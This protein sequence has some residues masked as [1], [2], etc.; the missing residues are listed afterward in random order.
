MVDDGRKV[1]EEKSPE[2][3]ILCIPVANGSIN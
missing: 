1:Q 3:G 2:A